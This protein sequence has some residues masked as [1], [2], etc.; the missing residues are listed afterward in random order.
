MS[1]ADALLPPPPEIEEQIRVRVGV[2]GRKKADIA[3]LHVGIVG[4]GDVGSIVAEA[5]AR[6][7]VSRLTLIDFDVVR[8]HNLDRLLHSRS[9]DA[10][11]KRPKIKTLSCGLR[12]SA[13]SRQFDVRQ[14]F[15]SVSEEMGFRALSI[16]TC[17]FRAST[18]RLDA[19][20]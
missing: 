7:G 2:G 15:A 3:R 12:K 5:L 1:F 16:A 6:T 19:A 17:C 4:A 10:Y 9:L 8:R 14:I 18:N 13:T 20:F 11:L